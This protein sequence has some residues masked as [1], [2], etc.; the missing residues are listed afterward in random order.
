MDSLKRLVTFEGMTIAAVIHQPRSDIVDMFDSIFLL[1]V[2][3]RTVY[4]GPATKCRTYFE[5]IGFEMSGGNSQADWYL[6]ISSGDV[7]TDDVESG[8]LSNN[9][10]SSS[11]QSKNNSY[12]VALVVDGNDLGFV[13]T[14]PENVVRGSFSVK[15]ISS[16]RYVAASENEI[17]VGDEVLGING[18]G[19]CQMTLSEVNT[20]LDN[21]DNCDV[22][23]I[24]LIHQEDKEDKEPDS[25]D[26]DGEEDHLLNDIKPSD[27]D[28]SLVKAR[29]AREKLYR[30]Y[31][32]HFENLPL[33]TKERYFNPP[34]P[35]DL[36]RM[37][38][39][40]SGLH[41]LLI[42]LRRNCLL[43]WRNRDAR[44]IDGGI[45]LMAIFLM[46]LLGGTKVRK[47][48]QNGIYAYIRG[49]VSTM[50]IKSP[51]STIF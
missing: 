3:G 6:D 11:R 16:V 24:Q 45:L 18:H 30:Q 51:I 39:P 15:E 47:F 2:G 33:S 4:H 25:I 12:E 17:Q 13:L 5:S 43:T 23:I 37:P 42:Q 10:R 14:Q 22:F 50:D 28:A 8:T 40:V 20:L 9:V 1:G 27:D 46:S 41:Q 31:K 21:N 26:D 29:L 34:K 32:V 19:L 48:V 35:F 36:P 44:L 7:E 38:R 49:L